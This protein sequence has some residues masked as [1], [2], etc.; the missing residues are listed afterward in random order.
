M[1]EEDMNNPRSGNNP[2]GFNE[3][4]IIHRSFLT[5]EEACPYG[6][7]AFTH[8]EKCV[9]IYREEVIQQGVPNEVHM[10]L[11]QVIRRQWSTVYQKR[12]Q[13]GRWE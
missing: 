2:N 10:R 4:E 9:T 13:A 5:S 3:R 6:D 1:R 7:A 11:H 8:I 12:N